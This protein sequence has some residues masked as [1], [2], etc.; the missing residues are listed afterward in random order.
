MLPLWMPRLRMPWLRM[1]RLRRLRL[2]MPRLHGPRRLPIPP[3]PRISRIPRKKPQ[4]S[5]KQRLRPFQWIRIPIATRMALPTPRLRKP[6]LHRL[7]ICYPTALEA[8]Q[9]RRKPD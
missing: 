7:Y 2:Q 1:P 5:Q 6:R 3:I 9:K 8:S 4:K